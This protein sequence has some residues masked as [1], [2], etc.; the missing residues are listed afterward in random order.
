MYRLGPILKGIKDPLWLHWVFFRRVYRF[1]NYGTQYNSKKAIA[2]LQYLL[3]YAPK[4]FIHIFG[5]P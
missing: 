5:S 1:S 3:I 4:R 2:G